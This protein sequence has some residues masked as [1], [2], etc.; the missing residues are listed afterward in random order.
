MRS[1][2]DAR[3]SITRPLRRVAGEPTISM[4]E[5]RWPASVPAVR[6]ILD[7][8]LDLGALTILVG[9]NGVGKSTVVEAIALAF[10]MSAEGGPRA[11]DI[12]RVP[13]SRTCMITCG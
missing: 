1:A 5:D 8:G 9:D 4:P 6:Q 13:P 3:P 10:G 2:R 7:T 11:P 12:R